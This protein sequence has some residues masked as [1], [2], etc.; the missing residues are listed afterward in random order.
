MVTRILPPA[1][2]QYLIDTPI[3][4]D[5]LHQVDTTLEE[6]PEAWIRGLIVLIQ[7]GLELLLAGFRL[8]YSNGSQ[9]SRRSAIQALASIAAGEDPPVKKLRT[10]H[11]RAIVEGYRQ[12]IKTTTG[13]AAVRVFCANMLGGLA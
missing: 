10:P 6:R 9:L 1:P 5:L 4:E 8:A 2:H 7:P 11:M 3:I 13:D 12:A